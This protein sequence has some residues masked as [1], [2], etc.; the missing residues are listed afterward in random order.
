MLIRWVVIAVVIGAWGCP[1]SAHTVPTL[2]VEA[3]FNMARQSEIRVNIDPRLFLASQP[4]TLPPIAAA[5]WLEQDAASR[6]KTGAAAVA[7]LEKTLGFRIGDAALRGDWKVTAIDSATSF[8][9]S[10]E[11]AEVHLLAERQQ[12]LPAV[13][14]EFKVN[15][16]DDCAVGVML[17]NSIEGKPERHPQALFPSESSRGFK[18]PEIKPTA[19]VK[20]AATSI[21]LSPV[22]EE[23][24]RFSAIQLLWLLPLAAVLLV[25]MGLRRRA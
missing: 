12:Q 23:H 15:V 22:T 8:P 25:L 3:E 5:W 1:L 6:A 11:S 2:V 24:G 17:M 14:G 10:S 4:T 9:L 21:E 19:P 20:L 7:Y 13:P 16:S 18:L